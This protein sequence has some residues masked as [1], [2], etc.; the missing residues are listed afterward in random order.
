LVPPGQIR[1]LESN[2]RPNRAVVGLLD[3]FRRL[4]SPNPCASSIRAGQTPGDFDRN[5]LS[6]TSRGASG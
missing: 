3:N 4:F 1:R 5:Q 6:G 2:A